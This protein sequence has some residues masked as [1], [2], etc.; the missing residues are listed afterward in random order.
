M[1]TGTFSRPRDVAIQPFVSVVRPG[2]GD[3]VDRTTS[4]EF[5]WRDGRASRYT[6]SIFD[7]GP[8]GFGNPTSGPLVNSPTSTLLTTTERSKQFVSKDL[9]SFFSIANPPQDNHRYRIEILVDT[10]AIDVLGTEVLELVYR[11]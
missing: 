7:L 6:V 8:V 1:V 4:L 11:R 2:F 9:K 10:A 5:H 3:R